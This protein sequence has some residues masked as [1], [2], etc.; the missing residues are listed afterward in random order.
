MQNLL[1]KSTIVFLVLL[2]VQTTF[3]QKTA[4]TAPTPE[5][6]RD[7]CFNVVKPGHGGCPVG[8]D[9]PAETPLLEAIR[10]RNIES[11]KRLISEGADVN[12]FD[13]RGF[14]PL[15]MVAGGDFELIDILL[16]A[17]ANVNAE[18][19]QGATPLINSTTCSRAVQKFLEAGADVNHRN[20]NKQ[21]A[22]TV[23][24]KTAILNR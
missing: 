12:Q 11:V 3:G 6:K 17:G 23:A 4:E 16:K 20:I 13:S 5:I 15:L 9:I 10:Q 18:S 21:T 24:A 2:V 1:S 22:L 7:F 19:K 8:E 14:S